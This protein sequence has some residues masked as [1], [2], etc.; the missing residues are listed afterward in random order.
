MNAI[1]IPVAKNTKTT[2]QLQSIAMGLGAGQGKPAIGK[3]QA[4]QF[5]LETP[6]ITSKSKFISDRGS[7][8]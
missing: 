2:I 7:W 8:G 1:K 6:A 3:K 4:P 5:R